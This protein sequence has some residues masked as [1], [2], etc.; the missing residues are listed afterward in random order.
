MVILSPDWL[1]RH[2]APQWLLIEEF[3][4]LNTPL[5]LLQHLCDES[6]QG[7]L[8]TQM[9]GMIAEYERAQIAERTRRGRV[10]KARHGECIPRA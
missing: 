6:P 4:K 7:Q 9:Q 2:D 5:I 10:E 8:R 3:E 1:A